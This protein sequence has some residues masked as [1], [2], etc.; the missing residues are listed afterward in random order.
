MRIAGIEFP[1]DFWD[2]LNDDKLVLFAGA[3][4][5][6]GKPA[7]LPDF[8]DLAR[9]IARGT[10]ERRKYLEPEESFLGRL[11]EQRGTRVHKRAARILSN[12]DSEPTNLH[13]D[14]L[15]LFKRDHKVRLVTTNFDGLFEQAVDSE[16]VF[17]TRPEVFGAPALPLGL[18]FTGIVHVH[19]AVSQPESMVLTDQDF[20]R[21]YLTEGWARRFLVD[22]FRTYTVLFVGYSHNDTIMNYLARALPKSDEFKRFALTDSMTA[23]QMRW[24]T[25]GIQT[26]SYTKSRGHRALHSGVN[27]LASYARRSILEWKREIETIAQNPLP[28]DKESADIIEESLKDPAKARFFAN[29]ASDPAWIDWLDERRHLD[30][31]FGHGKLCNTH[32]V[33]SWWLADRF[34]CSDTDKLFLL[35]GRHDG[36]LHP[37][38]W[39][40]LGRKITGSESEVKKDLLSQW[41]SVLSADIPAIPRT[42]QNILL[43]LGLRCSQ[44]RLLEHVIQL[45]DATTASRLI[46]E[47]GFAFDDDEVPIDAEVRM[48][49]EIYVVRGLWEDCLKPYLSEVARP[50][51][52]LL[53]R[54]LEQRYRALNPWGQSEN[55]ERPAIGDHEQNKDTGPSTVL[56]NAT[57]D[58]LDWLAENQPEAA[59]R[60]CNQ[61]AI[62]DAPLLRRLALHAASAQKEL[63]SGEKIHWL[64]KNA[65]IHD[66]E[67]HKEVFQLA[68]HAYPEADS[69]FK[70]ALIAR[71]FEYRWK[72][73]EHSGLTP[74]QIEACY[75]LDWLHWLHEKDPSCPL[76]M[77]ALNEASKLLP[78]YKPR[79]HPDFLSWIG[80][81]PDRGPTVEE[82]LAMPATAS[83]DELLSLQSAEQDSHARLVLVR[84]LTEAAKRDFSWGIALADGL[85]KAKNWDTNLWQ[86]LLYA[87]MNMELG[88]DDYIRVLTFLKLTK[89]HSEHAYEVANVLFSLVQNRGK[90]YA[91]NLL[92]QVNRIAI[93]LWQELDR[94]GIDDQ[95][96]DWLRRAH[97]HPA[98]RLTEFWL[99]GLSV[100][101]NAQDPMPDA[102]NDEFRAAFSM[103]VKD[104]TLPGKLGRSAL[105]SEFAFL[106]AADRAWTIE[107]LLPLF[108][109]AGDD[110]ELGREGLARVALYPAVAELLERAFLEAV[111]W[112]SSQGEYVRGQFIQRYIHMI[113]YFVEEP[114]STWI[115]KLFNDGGEDIGKVFTSSL[116]ENYLR[117]MDEATQREWWQRWLKDYWENRLEGVPNALTPKEVAQMLHWPAKLTAVFPE[118]VALATKMGQTTSD[119]GNLLYSL[120]KSNLVER[121]PNELVCFLLHLDKIG[122]NEYWWESKDLFKILLES[123]IS[124]ELKHSLRELMANQGIEE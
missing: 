40:K 2:A 53:V 62:S 110:W 24:Q 90:S 67:I 27:G 100:W 108:D 45:F 14:L 19:G 58:I 21:A 77:Q 16:D 30:A 4:V 25:L 93:T 57:R 113:A 6:K 28:H 64:L 120:E 106:L 79:E 13:K 87:W 89:L 112:S 34:A 81:V 102:L 50:I 35:I 92:S 7:G 65:D 76:A 39:W 42:E 10:G 55:W 71:I 20:G 29:A 11:K 68:G 5:S 95:Q 15:R 38:L 105:V 17:D 22:V 86:A 94:K 23:A 122:V 66:P 63:S 47:S 41:V 123:S 37:N 91:L 51:L 32:G 78:G 115:P 119:Y 61:L 43:D 99:Y 88:E 104:P 84:N 60:W 54:R 48:V 12:I 75:Q 118:A 49:G 18:D 52:E 98:G 97:D 33:L 124:E 9:A 70:E 121:F 117:K 3:G 74:K 72:G 83:L 56:V 73:G 109:S 107:N 31:L 116:N 59:S 69:K 111:E 44:C 1:Q 114:F 26:I 36:R 46:A 96:D 101:R 8:R 82:L 85:A 80:P 103:I